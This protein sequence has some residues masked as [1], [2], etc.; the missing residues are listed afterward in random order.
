MPEPINN[1][2]PLNLRVSALELGNLCLIATVTNR[3][4]NAV[5]REALRDFI[6]RFEMRGQPGRPVCPVNTKPS[7]S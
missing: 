2:E 4:I 1:P 5:A 3:S 6:I 7:S